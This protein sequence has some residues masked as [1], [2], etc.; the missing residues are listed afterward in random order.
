MHE[1]AFASSL[2]IMTGPQDPQYPQDP[3]PSYPPPQ[4][5]Y[6]QYG[7]PQ[8]PPPGQ[9][10][11]AQQPY[12]QQG[13]YPPGGYGTPVPRPS[14]WQRL[15]ARA[16]RRP[17]PRLGVTLTGVGVVL[18]IVGI[19]VWSFTYIIDGI[20]DGLF[21]GGGVASSDSRRYLGL[22]LALI[23]VAIGYALVVTARTGP[24]V[25]AGVAA[26]A[27]GIP[28]ALEFAT[29]DLSGGDPFNT[30]A[31]VW[32]SV[33]AY[34]I[35]Y[36]FVRGARGH[37][38]T[39]RWRSRSC[40]VTRSARPGRTPARSVRASSAASPA[41]SAARTAS[42]PRST[43][44]R[45]P[46]SRWS[47]PW[48]TSR[49]AFVLDRRGRHG[50]ALPF[51]VVGIPAMLLG[52]GMLAPDTEQVGTGIILL[53]VG[54]VLCRYGARYGRRFTA[55]FWGLSAAAG[56]VAIATKFATTGVGLGITMIVLGVV[57][58]AGGWLAARSLREPDDMALVAARDAGAGPAGR[59]TAGLSAAAS[60]G[61]GAWPMS[62]C[63][64]PART[65]PPRS[66]GSRST[67]GVRLRRRSCR[68]PCSSVTVRRPAAP[69]RRASPRRRRL[70]PRAR[71]AGAEHAGRVHR[72]RPRPRT[73]S[74]TTRT[75][76]HGRRS[77]RCW[78]NRGGA[79]AGT[80]RG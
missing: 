13:Q 78:S 73:C 41:V 25:T 21:S 26:S 57:F 72:P 71:R 40:G 35:S 53:L 6:G 64:R 60:L 15:G 76:D 62:V 42:S 70:A 18:V 44:S 4:G 10:Y 19:L 52:I 63:A 56:A 65:M 29:F 74:P 2:L 58:A 24:L 37:T 23:V 55:W 61:S 17:A 8:Y 47:S 54:V 36:L 32:V 34:L 79:G 3:Q 48:P 75:R 5:P 43:T 9:Q 51:A 49:I 69:G 30:D 66:R 68:P 77:A 45:S 14:L 31:I 39:W 28:L 7:A 46:R 22:A 20:R 80:A 16:E 59:G 38:S 67:P 33:I 50:T 1:A 27:L 12:Q 11:P